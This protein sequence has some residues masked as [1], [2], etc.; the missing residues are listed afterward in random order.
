M[1]GQE[2]NQGTRPVRTGHRLDPFSAR[3]SGCLE[4]RAN[5]ET[6]SE[7]RDAECR[8]GQYKRKK[9]ICVVGHIKRPFCPPSTYEACL[10][11]TGASSHHLRRAPWTSEQRSARSPPQHAVRAC[12]QHGPRAGSDPC[13]SRTVCRN[14]E[15]EVPASES[16]LCSE[17]RLMSRPRQ[18]SSSSA[19][20]SSSIALR[21]ASATSLERRAL[22]DLTPTVLQHATAVSRGISTAGLALKP[23]RIE[24][25][26]RLNLGL[27]GA[28]V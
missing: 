2:P 28:I 21:I 13:G 5:R 17:L 1:R 18:T 19:E 22:V 4:Q 6:Y 12:A 25:R 16:R 26:S 11:Q 20:P 8:D 15:N 23:A 3:V 24:A 10:Q 14:D 27:C 7:A 9:T